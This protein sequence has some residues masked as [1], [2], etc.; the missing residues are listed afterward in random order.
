MALKLFKEFWLPAVVAVAWT[1][2]N[3]ATAGVTWDIKTMVNIFG[4]SFFLASWATGQFFR[5]R[6]QA[7]VEKNLS[8][9]ESRVEGLVDRL[10]KHTKD[11]LGYTTGAD[12]VAYFTPMITAPGIV[13][14]GLQNNSTYP[15]FDIHAELIDLDEPIDPANGKFWTRHSFSIESLYPSKIVMSAFRF[16]LSER[17]RLRINVFIHTRTQGLTQQFRFQKI[18]DRIHIATKTTGGNDV[19]EMNVAPDFPEYDPAN[20]DAV[21]S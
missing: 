15:V 17:E 6:K 13:E 20:P 2:Y 14:L 21:F 5:I 16:D 4:P 12:S 8:S 9:I 7:N 18:A 1:V 3:I 10:E 11:F 19:I